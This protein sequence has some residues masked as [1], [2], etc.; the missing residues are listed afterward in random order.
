MS[1]NIKQRRAELKLTLEQIGNYV[2][3]SKSTVKKWESGN[4]K[5]MR[6]DKIL[7]LSQIL[8]VSPLDFLDF[9]TSEPNT[10]K[11][12]ENNITLSAET[13]KKIEC[14]IGTPLSDAVLIYKKG[15]TYTLHK[16]PESRLAS[17]SEH[18]F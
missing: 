12:L 2:G 17:I 9:N 11:Q 3:V 16:I 15:T 14:A 6:R 5:N 13:V 10:K 1:I 18:I 7:L 4:I 8:K